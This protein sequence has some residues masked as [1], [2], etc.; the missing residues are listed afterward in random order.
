VREAHNSCELAKSQLAVAKAKSEDYAA[1]AGEGLI[2]YSDSLDARAELYA[3]EVA[4]VRASF[5]EQITIE[6][7]RYVMGE[8]SD[9]INNTLE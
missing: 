8:N 2:K 6:N 1:R 5:A 4:N 7:L 3:A 9:K